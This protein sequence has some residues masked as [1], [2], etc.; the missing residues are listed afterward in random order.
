[1]EIQWSLVVFSLLAGAGGASMA[2][3]GLAEARGV[4]RGQGNG[5]GSEQAGGAGSE[6][7]SGTGFIVS[8]IAIFALVVGGLAAVTH[9]G[10][11][12]NVMSAIG[13]IFSFSGISMELALLGLTLIAA[14][15]YAVAARRKAAGAAK[16]MGVVAMVLGILLCLVLGTSYML[17][18]RPAWNNIGLPLAYLCSSLAVGGLLYCAVARMRGVSA[19]GLG[20]VPACALAA[21]VLALLAFLLFGLLSG[22]ASDPG[23]AAAF[24]GLAVVVGGVVPAACAFM[25]RSKEASYIPWLGLAGAAVGA[26]ALRALM[27][28]AGSPMLDIFG[29][30]SS[31]T[32]F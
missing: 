9:L 32:P 26:V 17:G 15:V 13:N 10:N 1:M 29:S 19:A 30:A 27:W 18:A 16:G 21:S 11:P 24:W 4:G 7:G 31:F 3:V 6:Q 2:F 5:A 23:L 22:V 8:I 14:V 12:A 20:Q 25:M 28:L